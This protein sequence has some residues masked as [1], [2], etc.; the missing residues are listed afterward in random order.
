MIF[1]LEELQEDVRINLTPMIDVVFLLIIFFMVATTFV[2]EEKEID[3]KLPETTSASPLQSLPE[4]VVIN[5]MNDGRI[6]VAGRVV[7]DQALAGLLKEAKTRNPRQSAIIRGDR[8]TRYE[9]V[10][11]VVGICHA[12]AVGTSLAA[13]EGSETSGG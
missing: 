4:E 8:G 12:V 13:L 6:K 1:D 11:R 5:V 9:H 3:L 7:S 2:R 10:V